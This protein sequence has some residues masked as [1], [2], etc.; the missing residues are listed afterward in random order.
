MLRNGILY[1]LP[2]LAPIV[3]ATAS[4][5][6]PTPMK[7][8]CGPGGSQGCKTARK[9]IGRDWYLPEE[10]EQ[11]MGFPIGWTALEPAETP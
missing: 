4:G 6:L 8:R 10:A 11:I 7:S 2:P 9:L 3:S 1:Q 5:L